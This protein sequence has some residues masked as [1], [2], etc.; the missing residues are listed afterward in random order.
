MNSAVHRFTRTFLAG[1]LAA[2]PLAATVL[3]LV[4]VVRLLMQWLGPESLIGRFLIAI[5]IGT[6]GSEVVGYLIGIGVMLAG[7][8]ALGMVVRSR[9][10][11]VLALAVNNVLQRI[12]VVRTIYDLAKK[13]VDLLAQKDAA[14]TKS[15]SPVWL[16][17]GGTG[18]AAVLGLL[19][20]NAPV[21]VGG[22]PY[23]AVLVPTAPVP[24]GGGLL[25]VPQAWVTPAEIGI[26]GLT[27]IY[28]SMGITSDK[29]LAPAIPASP[30]GQTEATAGH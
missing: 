15:M 8:F 7:I 17:F 20:T 10:R 18:G 19:S 14:G 25:Y 24:V 16:H 23:L 12:P 1:L 6:T 2:L 4:W 5:G 26:D 27:S 28:V 30:G 21:M 29:Y 11:R 13:F 9:M 3:I 22:E